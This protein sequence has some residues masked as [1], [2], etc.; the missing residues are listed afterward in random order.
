MSAQAPSSPPTTLEGED[1]G[2]QYGEA[3]R[4]PRRQPA[5]QNLQR[6][7]AT[8][9]R[10]MMNGVLPQR[11]GASREEPPR[12]EPREAAPTGEGHDRNLGEAQAMEGRA[13]GLAPIHG[14]A[15]Q[16]AVV[17]PSSSAGYESLPT[18]PSSPQRPREGQPE[19]AE[20]TVAMEYSFQ[21]SEGQPVVRWVARLSEFL[22]SSTRGN[23]FQGRVLEGLGL[24]ATTTQHSSGFQMVQ[25]QPYPQQHSHQQQQPLQQNAAAELTLHPAAAPSSPFS[26]TRPRDLQN[27]RVRQ[28]PPPPPLPVRSPSPP[29]RTCI[30]NPASTA[31]AKDRR[32]P[33]VCRSSVVDT[34]ATSVEP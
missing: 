3:Q 21:S 8:G 18:R 10:P 1:A 6:D 22:R 5:E 14:V 34:G 7:Q 20:R 23:G 17:S 16:A 24:G 33:H 19:Q 12:V 28:A 9:A 32:L 11:E 26:I 15:D 4:E 13:D 29:T 31:S 2:P 30:S 27:Y 25:Q